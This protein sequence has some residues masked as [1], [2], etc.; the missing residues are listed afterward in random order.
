MSW[1]D[2]SRHL[3]S[4]HISMK[5]LK[6]EIV[7]AVFLFFAFYFLNLTSIS[8][9]NFPSSRFTMEGGQPK[10]IS[11]QHSIWWKSHWI[12]HIHICK[13]NIKSY[14]GN[15]DIYQRTVIVLLLYCLEII[16]VVYTLTGVSQV[17]LML[18][19]PLPVKET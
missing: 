3:T 4:V 14:T 2:W 15:L 16:A 9:R 11:N 6:K 18:K 17:A 8:C 19:N 10:T 12:L 7:C 5:A 1:T 13:V